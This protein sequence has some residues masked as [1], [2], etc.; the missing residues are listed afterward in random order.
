MLD[1]VDWTRQFIYGFG[2]FLGQAVDDNAGRAWLTE[3][4]R[5]DIERRQL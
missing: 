2:Q 1:R 5:E 3:L 4:K